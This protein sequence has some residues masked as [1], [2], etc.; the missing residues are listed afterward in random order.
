MYAVDAGVTSGPSTTK[1][2]GQLSGC[3]SLAMNHASAAQIGRGARARVKARYE[4]EEAAHVYAQVSTRG[5]RV[6]EVRVGAHRR[7]RP[8]QGR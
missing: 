2:A 5:A 1:P 6:R 8:C 7:L 3:V 4:E